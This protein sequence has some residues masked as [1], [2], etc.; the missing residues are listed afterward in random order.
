[1]RRVVA[2]VARSTSSVSR[3]RCSSALAKVEQR[4]RDRQL[5]DER[6]GRRGLEPVREPIAFELLVLR[7]HADQ[8]AQRRRRF[9]QQRVGA[10]HFVG[11]DARVGRVCERERDGLI[12]RDGL[13]GRSFG[14]RDHRRGIVGRELRRS[15]RR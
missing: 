14:A 8:R 13:H 7:L 2:A 15:R 4:H 9:L 10:D 12:E 11:G 5:A 1:V 3:A 6:L